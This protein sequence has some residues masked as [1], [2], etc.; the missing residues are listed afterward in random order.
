MSEEKKVLLWFGGAL[1]PMGV[2][3]AFVI[4]Y[5]WTLTPA[6]KE[7]QTDAPVAQNSSK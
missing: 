6:K 2:V 4:S 1:L 7:G 5:L 3:L